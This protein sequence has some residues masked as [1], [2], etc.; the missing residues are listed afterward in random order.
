MTQALTFTIV[1]GQLLGRKEAPSAL[2]ELKFKTLWPETRLN[3]N[4]QCGIL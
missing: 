1:F 4:A 3:M 2:P